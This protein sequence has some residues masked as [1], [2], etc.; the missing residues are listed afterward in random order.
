[1]TDGHDPRFLEALALVNDYFP[2]PAVAAKPDPG[3][4]IREAITY[5]RLSESGSAANQGAAL[6]AGTHRLVLTLLKEFTQDA[7]EP[8]SGK[9][10]ENRPGWQALVDYVKTLPPARRRTSCILV[11]SFDRF[12]RS[13][14][15][16]L[17]TERT[18]REELG[19]R[20]RALDSPFVCPET[21]QGRM[22]FTFSLLAAE[23]YRLDIEAKT[24]RGI[25]IAR[26]PGG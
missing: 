5:G 14:E 15:E 4:D 12:S 13:V 22:M 7:E 20:L 16:G 19:I 8:I 1:M 11:V 3:H 17:A 10:F 6:S 25:A 2:E 24:A 18:V 9:A 21:S 23:Q 26:R